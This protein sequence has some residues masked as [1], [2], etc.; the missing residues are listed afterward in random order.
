[1]AN[2]DIQSSLPY[3]TMILY[4]SDDNTIQNDANQEELHHSS[5]GE[6]T[7]TNNKAIE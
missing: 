3:H 7:H 4:F 2:L 6:R 1:M 5:T